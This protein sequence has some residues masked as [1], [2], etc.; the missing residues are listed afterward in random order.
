MQAGA[1]RVGTNVCVI[2]KKT[3]GISMGEGNTHDNVSALLLGA[4]DIA[5]PDV[6]DD[7]S[8]MEV[9]SSVAPETEIL[10]HPI[11]HQ[12]HSK[13]QILCQCKIT[14]GRI[15]DTYP[16]TYSYLPRYLITMIRTHEFWV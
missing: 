6:T 8:L 9:D 14:I 3:V 13:M 15:N 12:H 5:N 7:V 10:T 4:L 11:F 2:I 1:T 16:A